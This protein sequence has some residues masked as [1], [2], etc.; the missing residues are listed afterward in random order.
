[1]QPRIQL[2]GGVPAT[3]NTPVTFTQKI[4]FNGGSNSAFFQTGAS[5]ATGAPDSGELYYNSVDGLVLQARTG[6]SYDL[7]LFNPSSG[8]FI[9]MVPTGTQ[10]VFFGGLVNLPPVTDAAPTVGDLYLDATQQNTATQTGASGAPLKGFLDS[11][12]WCTYATGGGQAAS[13][14][15]KIG[16]AH[17]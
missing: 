11:T 17:V 14:T 2:L 8:S 10:N 16:R 7:S 13:V 12:F 3:V 5:Q 4:Y 9:F 1:M 15:C 6:S